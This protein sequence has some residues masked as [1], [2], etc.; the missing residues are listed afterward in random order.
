MSK[1]LIG[2]SSS[3]KSTLSLLL[4]S[5]QYFVWCE[6][7]ELTVASLLKSQ[8]ESPFWR[9]QINRD[10]ELD[11]L[12]LD[13]HSRLSYRSERTANQKK[14]PVQGRRSPFR[15]FAK[16]KLSPVI[17]NRLAYVHIYIL[18][19]CIVYNT[20]KKY[21]STKGNGLCAVDGGGRLRVED[22]AAQFIASIKT[23][24]LYTTSLCATN[25]AKERWGG[26]GLYYPFCIV[27]IPRRFLS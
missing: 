7:R 17:F 25:R 8:I 12:L 5:S 6:C 21:V 22:T 27:W 10:R 16:K 18:L 4:L 24:S 11:P 9:G 2:E 3:S 14:I 19:P 13:L 26:G 1:L 23:R 20:Q 15:R